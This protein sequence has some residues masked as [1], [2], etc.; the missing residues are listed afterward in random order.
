VDCGEG[1]GLW[2]GGCD[3]THRGGIDPVFGGNSDG[4]GWVRDSG[5]CRFFA[6]LGWAIQGRDFRGLFGELGYGGE[7]FLEEGIE[8]D[9]V[10]VGPVVCGAGGRTREVGGGDAEAGEEESGLLVV[11]VAGGDA[12]EDFE[13]GE[14]DGVAIVD[15]RHLEGAVVAVS[16]GGFAAGTVVV[17]AEVVAAEGGRAA[18]G[19][20]GVDV[21]ALIAAG[22]IGGQVV[23][24]FPPY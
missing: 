22:W 11:D 8:G 1:D 13:E 20:T 24:F 21:T 16:V 5:R 6:R 23:H 4:D 3:V 7:I 10:D 15:A 12:A 19:A 2:G 9:F 14:L 17:E 18:A